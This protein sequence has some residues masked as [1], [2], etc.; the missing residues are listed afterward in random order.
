M[1]VT[2]DLG[3]VLSV[4]ELIAC[5]AYLVFLFV[6]KEETYSKVIRTATAS[7]I[8]VI[9]AFQI[10]MDIQMEKSYV[11][12]IAMVII[13]LINVVISAVSLGNDL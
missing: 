11:L 13:W 10:P 12:S 4:V 9:N 8:V 1:V 2:I 3:L 6:G 7:A 5:I